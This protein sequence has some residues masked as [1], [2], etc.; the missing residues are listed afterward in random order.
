MGAELVIREAL[1]KSMMRS[2]TN[3]SKL[4]AVRDRNKKD[5]KG[6]LYRFNL[7]NWY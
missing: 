3:F 5:L 7:E 2:Y 1:A 6:V 4:R